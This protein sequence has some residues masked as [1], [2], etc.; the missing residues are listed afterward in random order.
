[1][2]NSIGSTQRNAAIRSTAAVAVST[3][4][5][6]GASKMAAFFKMGAFKGTDNSMGHTHY[7]FQKGALR[8]GHGG[9]V[10]DLYVGSAALS[11][12]TAKD[13]MKVAPQHLGKFVGEVKGKLV[14]EKA[15]V[16]VS[17]EPPVVELKS[18][19]MKVPL[20]VF[21]EAVDRKLGAFQPNHKLDP[22]D[23]DGRYAVYYFA[24]G[25]VAV[26]LAQTDGFD[27]QFPGGR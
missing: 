19:K 8:C 7:Y 9:N 23:R 14:F 22:A 26:P 3:R 16:D 21:V 11:G 2:G 5:P 24:K 25:T 20:E 12:E 10:V 17:K 6:P 13:L 18:P 1:M 15:S 27:S 4:I